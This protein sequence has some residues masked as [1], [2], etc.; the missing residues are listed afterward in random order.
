MPQSSLAWFFAIEFLNNSRWFKDKHNTLNQLIHFLPL[1]K[2]REIK[3]RT[4]IK[5][6]CKLHSFVTARK[7]WWIGSGKIKPTENKGCFRESGQNIQQ[8][9]RRISWASMLRDFI[10]LYYQKTVGFC[11]LPNKLPQAQINR[12]QLRNTD[13]QFRLTIEAVRF[14]TH[15]FDI[16]LFS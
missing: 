9:R 5:P 11:W 10:K 8:T 6:S 3:F 13:E 16:I 2:C 1:L 12:K 4:Y 15:K 7:L 14:I